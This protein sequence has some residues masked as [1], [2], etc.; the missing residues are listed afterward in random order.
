[1]SAN[2][3]RQTAADELCQPLSD[4]F[5]ALIVLMLARRSG[6]LDALFQARLTPT[7]FAVQL[8]T[9]FNFLVGHV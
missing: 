8:F 5:E 3:C 4:Y 9:P 7:T 1:L 6:F 2:P